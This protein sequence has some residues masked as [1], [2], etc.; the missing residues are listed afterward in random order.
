M[1]GAWEETARR[2]RLLSA[3]WR[4]I[5]QRKQ[6]TKEAEDP[7][8]MTA[9]VTEIHV[10]SVIGIVIAGARFVRHLFLASSLFSSPRILSICAC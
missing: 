2:L 7:R 3:P 6:R 9:P 10:R 4:W 8:M 5:K 1:G